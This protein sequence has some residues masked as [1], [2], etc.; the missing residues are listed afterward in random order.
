[1]NIDISIDILDVLKLLAIFLRLICL[2]KALKKNSY[3]NV[4]ENPSEYVNGL[5]IYI[6]YDRIRFA[7]IGQDKNDSWYIEEDISYSYLV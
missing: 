3:S 6:K 2:F 5:Y 7:V 4:P 1:M